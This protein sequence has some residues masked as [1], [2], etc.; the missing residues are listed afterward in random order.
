MAGSALDGL[1]VI[2]LT[3]HLSGPYCSM[4]LADQGADVVKVER[5]GKGDETRG[6]PPFVAGESAP[7]MLV[8]RNKSSIVL[9]L[10]NP[11]DREACRGLAREADVFI[12]NFKPGTAARLGLGYEALAA[13]NP[14]LV[15]CSI[16][17]FGQTGPYRDRGGFDLIVQGMSGMM[18]VNGPEDGPPHR[19]P[20]PIADI[21]TGMFAAIGILA[22]LQARAR[23]GRGQQVDAA[24][25]DSAVALGVYEAASYFATGRPPARLGQA[26]RGAAPYQI[27]R[28][29]DGWITIGGASQAIW[30]RLCRALG[31][32]DLAEDPR[33]KDNAAR[34]ANREALVEVLQAI[35][36]GAPT[37]HWVATLQAADIPA[38]PVQSYDAVLADPQVRAREMVAEIG[39]PGAGRMAVLGIPVKLSA[40]PGDLRR[41][42]PRLGEH[43]GEVLGEGS[44]G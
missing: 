38:G 16:S 26:H 21:T 33:F 42:A 4:I 32:P 2:D 15:Y 12:E 28:T 35:L 37:S 11:E 34:V 19:L 3:S 7:F 17:G 6:M 41:P 23:T 40:T 9:D 25:Y 20:M 39:H 10:K 44:A 30:L 29:A 24:L 22:A 1:R 36:A 5:P 18:S 8:N 43:N 13:L 27:F 31:R 14:R